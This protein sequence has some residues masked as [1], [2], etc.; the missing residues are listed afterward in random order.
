MSA[1]HPQPGS[2]GADAV[3]G[4]DTRP[5][6]ARDDAADA[7]RL[8]QLAEALDAAGVRWWIDHGTLLG[9]VRD[10]TPLPW[11]DDIDVSLGHDD[12][13][14]VAQAIVGL[15]P[16]LSSR[17]VITARNVKIVPYA[18][19]ER[20]IDVAS[21]RRLRDGTMEKG[22]VRVPTGVGVGRRRGR[23]ALRWLVYRV[24]AV[25]AL[26]DRW[27]WS[28]W[29]P[30][31]RLARALVGLTSAV[32]AGRERFG[33]VQP[34]RVPPGYFERLGTVR[35]GALVLPAPADPEAYLALRYGPEWRVP[36]QAWTWWEDD[37][38]IDDAEHPRGGGERAANREAAAPGPQEASPRSRRCHAS[39]TPKR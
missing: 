27:A 15:R 12:L 6:V 7:R 14:R 17:V 23:D 32:A 10:G 37:D 9:L 18:R 30:P 2:S 19:H 8:A 24:D 26:C 16:R 4:E 33:R 3:L 28:A 13:P 20:T 31:P 38:T 29:T 22:L 11:D 25:L 1:A 21:Y 36:R 39:N 34:S 35:W 5:T